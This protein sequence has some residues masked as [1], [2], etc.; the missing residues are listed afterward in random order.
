MDLRDLGSR[1]LLLR[2]FNTAPSSTNFEIQKYYQSE[3][4]FNGFCSR[5]SLLKTKFHD[6]MKDEAY[7]IN[8]DEYSDIG[9]L[10]MN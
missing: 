2:I 7:V 5:D 10:C 1:N 3:P 4:K 8:L 9:L 6:K